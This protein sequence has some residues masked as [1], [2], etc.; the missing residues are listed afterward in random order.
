VFHIQYSLYGKNVAIGT[1]TNIIK[2]QCKPTPIYQPGQEGLHL[3][4]LIQ[5]STNKNRKD[6]VGREDITEME[7]ADWVK[8]S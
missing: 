2:E 5:H 4:K 8:I 6:I 1:H 3:H 7:I